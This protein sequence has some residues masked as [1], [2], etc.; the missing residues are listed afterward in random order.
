MQNNVIILTLFST[1]FLHFRN[2]TCDK[3]KPPVIVF[4]LP[5]T[6]AALYTTESRGKQVKK[7]PR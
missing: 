1:C 6:N 4:A 2:G 7:M 5:V 3:S